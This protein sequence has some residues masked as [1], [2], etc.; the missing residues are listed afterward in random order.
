MY[1]QSMADIDLNFTSTNLTTLFELSG[2][3][4]STFISISAKKKLVWKEGT[5]KRLD[6]QFGDNSFGNFEF[7]NFEGYEQNR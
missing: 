5:L 7:L 3:S 6:F 2:V 1:Q 4:I